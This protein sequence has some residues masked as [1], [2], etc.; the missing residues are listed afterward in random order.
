MSETHCV[1]CAEDAKVI[2]QGRYY[3]SKCWIKLFKK[4]VHGK[5]G[6]QTRQ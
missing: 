3:C 1:E 5:H 4:V 6:K 2:E